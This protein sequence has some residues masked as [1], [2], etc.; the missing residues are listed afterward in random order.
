[1]S[2]GGV[3]ARFHKNGPRRGRAAAVLC[4]VRASFSLMR[5][6]LIELGRHRSQ[7]VLSGSPSFYDT[8]FANKSSTKRE[9]AGPRPRG[10]RA[11]GL[12]GPTQL[13]RLYV[14]KKDSDGQCRFIIVNGHTANMLTSKA[15][16]NDFVLR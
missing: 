6:T 15:G 16:L 1:M 10:G 3:L 12:L 4:S 13:G 7:H 9:R 11:T 5:S 14:L 8:E 2:A